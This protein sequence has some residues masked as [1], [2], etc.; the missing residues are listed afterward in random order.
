MGKLLVGE[1]EPFDIKECPI[2]AIPQIQRI[3]RQLPTAR[4]DTFYQDPVSVGTDFAMAGLW[5]RYRG[6]L[7]RTTIHKRDM[8]KHITPLWYNEGCF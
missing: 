3:L 4:P 6:E 2:W 7:I 1:V 8:N 5:L